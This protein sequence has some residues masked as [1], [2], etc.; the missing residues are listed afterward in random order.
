[1]ASA[2][3]H[4]VFV[5]RS[6]PCLPACL[7]A[8]CFMATLPRTALDHATSKASAGQA[9]IS[10]LLAASARARASKTATER[11]RTLERCSAPNRGGLP[12]GREETSRLEHAVSAARAGRE[13]LEVAAFGNRSSDPERGT[14]ARF[15][16]ALAR[17]ARRASAC[18]CLRWR[19]P[20]TAGA[21]VSVWRPPPTKCSERVEARECL[22]EH[23]RVHLVR[24]LVGVD[25]LE[26]QH[27]ADHGVLE[28]DAVAAQDAATAP[29]DV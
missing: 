19:R 18:S 26:V 25:A 9:R 4:R 21:P 10:R 6:L 8:C 7:P 28:Q 15:C 17:W 20:T 14:C 27:V 24:A 13:P 12:A 23:E 2:D 11:T 1:M 5:A 3:V 22:A 16:G 29:G